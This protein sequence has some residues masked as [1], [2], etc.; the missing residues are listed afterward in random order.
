MRL[1]VHKYAG[2]HV[3]T[4]VYTLIFVFL[5]IYSPEAKPDRSPSLG[6]PVGRSAWGRPLAIDPAMKRQARPPDQRAKENRAW[7]PGHESVELLGS[8]G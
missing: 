3:S 7:K 6:P 1:A 8:V 4:S 5:G 2:M